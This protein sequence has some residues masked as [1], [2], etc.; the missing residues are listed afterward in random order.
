METNINTN[1]NINRNPYYIY[2]LSQMNWMLEQGCIPIRIGKGTSGDLYLKF[3]R[4]L[5]NE[6]KVR[7]W[8]LGKN[9]LKSNSSNG[10]YDK[11]V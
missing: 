3:P 10:I 9:I 4:T 2:D 7:I 6:E 11:R 1:R 8:K 5:E